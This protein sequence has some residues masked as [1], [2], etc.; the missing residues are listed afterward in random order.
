MTTLQLDVD[1]GERF[2]DAQPPLHEAVVDQ[3]ADH[4]DGHDDHDRD[5][6]SGIHGPLPEN[7]AADTAGRSLAGDFGR[8]PVT[9][10]ARISGTP[11]CRSP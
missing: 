11:R 8:S 9:N 2:V 1:L 6:D 5:D 10:E 4:N 7:C 3:D